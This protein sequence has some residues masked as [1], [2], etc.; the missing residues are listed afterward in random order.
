MTH[1]ELRDQYE[2]YAIGVA[3]EPVRD[4][5]RGHLARGCEECMLQMRH[6][7][8]LAVLFGASPDAAAPSPKLRRR[9]LA[10]VGFEQR[11]FGWAPWLGLAT[12]LSLFAAFY[13]SMRERQFAEIALSL[14]DQMRRQTVELTQLNEAFSILSG[15]STMEVNFGQ[16]PKGK[17]YIDRSRGV[18]LI[19]NNLPPAPA[20]KI[21]EMWTI[22]KGSKPVPAGL[23]QS[24]SN[25]GALHIQ[26]GA[27]DPNLAVVAVTL[28]N[29]AGAA[30]PTSTPILT[31]MLQ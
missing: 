27:V 8:E 12:A 26:T 9:I 13:F 25:G 17:V 11:R 3:D 22:A 15:P 18:L 31:A 16:G 29:E 28:E 4:E 7:R 2:L 20:G 14:R 21:Y 30:Q 5:I 6:A 19:A 24:Q 10:S 23:F 1:E